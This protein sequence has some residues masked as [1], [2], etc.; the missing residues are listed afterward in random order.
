MAN[1]FFASIKARFF[2]SAADTAVDIGVNGD[3]NPRVSIDAGGRINWGDGS[4][5]VDTNLY[6]DATNVLKTDDTFKAPA[7]YIDNIEVDT[8]G[9]T[10][11]QFLVF[12]GTK[13][14]PNT[15]G[16]IIPLTNLSDVAITSAADG[17]IL[18][19]N[20]S[21]WVN[22][23][24][25]SVEPMGHEDRTQ[26]TVSFDALTRV[27]TIA[28]VSTDYKVWCKGVRYIKTSPE[29][30]TVPNTT[31][32]YYIYFDGSGVLSYRTTYFDWDDDT[33]TAYIYWN[34]N[35]SKV[36]F[37]ADERHG[38]TLDWQTHEY[39][40]RTRGAVIA[41]G[42][43]AGAYVIDGDGSL[44][45][46]AQLDLANGTFFDE[47]LQVDIVHA[48]SPTPN[49]WEQV[50]Q[51]AAEIPIYRLAGTEWVSDTA[52][53]FP[54]KQG[55]IT[56]RYNSFTS[57]NWGLT[58][59]SNNKYGVSWVIATNNLNNPVIAI[60]G[61]NQYNQLSDIEADSWESLNLDNFPV[62]EFRPLYKVAYQAGTGFTNTP[63][64]AIRGVYDIRRVL[65]V[66][67][68]VPAT[69]VLDHGN[70][71]GLS[72][73]DHSQY[74]HLS[75]NRTITASHTFTNG[76]AS[77]GVVSTSSLVV[78]SIE[79]D[80]TGATTNQVL[81]FDGTKFL[82]VGTTANATAVISDLEPAT[83]QTGDLWYDSDTGSMY[84][85]Y[86]SY[87]VEIGGP[88]AQGPAGTMVQLFTIPGVVTTGSGKG[89]YY[90]P[91]TMVI[92]NVRAFVDD[93]PAGSDLIIDVNRNGTTIFTDQGNRPRI[94]AGNNY[95][96]GSTPDVTGLVAGDYVTIDIDQIGSTTAGTY[97]TVQIEFAPIVA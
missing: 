80:T 4:S 82:P 9:A 11:N 60:L 86:D 8:T 73:D 44:D 20:G 40:H 5:S 13:F 65:S 27:F 87:W 23:V 49:T 33:P 88:G 75:N 61:Q 19:Y 56:P 41:S 45:S 79:I 16:E 52:T 21:S 2:N 24:M 6:R 28:P 48:A 84:V 47:D 31:G 76:L 15:G 43:G 71:T 72:D 93:A 68:A 58:D 69:P 91:T 3:T 70:L 94:T 54:L 42:F 36:E 63:K 74:V 22:S 26:S 78:D 62:F 10:T 17:Q 83:A 81:K 50:L 77:S 89:R 30:V 37:F 38:V 7:L 95:D 39:L 1:K 32:L 92:S 18:Q 96:A 25:P 59:I 66:G 64:A 67:E 57:P 46:H 85:Y 12:D 34:A 51:G 35:T 55:V 97:L 90:A 14:A 29:T 53:E